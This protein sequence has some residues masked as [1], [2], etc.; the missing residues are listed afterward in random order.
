LTIQN[1]KARPVGYV[2]NNPQANSGFASRNMA[3]L[4]TLILIFIATHM[5]NFWAKM[6]FEEMPLQKIE[7]N[8]VGEIQTYYTTTQVGKYIPEDISRAGLVIKNGNEFYDGILNIKIAEGYKD[9]HK[10]VIAFFKDETFG[11]WATLFYI[12]SMLVMAFHLW[13]GFQ[14]AFQSIGFTN[15]NYASK[16]KFIGKVFAV[17][18]PLLFAVIPFYIHFIL[19]A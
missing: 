3:V 14:S 15:P 6:H 13:H 10:I 5:Q 11:L 8:N 16:I 4:G 17:T 18:V 2:K 1:K 9:L 7:I 12:F 19:K